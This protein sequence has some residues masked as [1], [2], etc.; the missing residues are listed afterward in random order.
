MKKYFLSENGQHI[1]PFSLDELKSKNIQKTELVW[2]EGMAD[3]QEGGTIDE[4]KSIFA[5][6]PPPAPKVAPPPTPPPP[7]QAHAAPPPPAQNAYA[8]PPP[9]ATPRPQAN[10]TN[11]A[12]SNTGGY[13][14][15]A[16]G[17][18]ITAGY[19]FMIVG[20]FLGWVIGT[21]LRF[22][23]QKLANGTKVKKFD[24]KSQQIGLRLIIIGGISHIIWLAILN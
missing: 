21:H 18:W 12:Q 22:S 23:K 10:Y 14:P 3:W 13:I 6:T 8:A 16:G 11:Q 9:P 15:Q 20:G 24:E 5:V 4:L 2:A 19:I 1:G 7:P 17:S